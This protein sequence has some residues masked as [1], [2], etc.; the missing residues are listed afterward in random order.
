MKIK[1]SNDKVLEPLMV[2]GGQQYVQ[3]QSRDTLSFVFDGTADMAELDQ[4][5]RP[6]NCGDIIITDDADGEYLHHGY[7]I[8]YELKKADVESKP[9]TAQTAAEYVTRITVSM[10]Q[11]SYAEEQAASLQETVDALVLDAL[12]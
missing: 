6:E 10:A 9:A 7:A 3:G 1:L 12:G 8:R 5:F 11:R 2:T 4:A